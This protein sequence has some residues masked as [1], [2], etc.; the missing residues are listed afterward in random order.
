MSEY[1]RPELLSDRHDLSGFDC[2]SDVLNEWLRRFAGQAMR[3]DMGRVFVVTPKGSNNVVAFYGLTVGAI[4]QE[5]ATDAL[6]RRVGNYPIPVVLLTRLGVDEGHA[7]Q[8]LG[9]GLMRDAFLRTID[10]STQVGIRAFHVHA[11]DDQALKFYLA[12]A[13]FEP[14]P[15]SPLHLMIAMKDV[16]AALGA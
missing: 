5:D 1:I 10:A 4:E 6:R 9:R 8:G 3:N 14:S 13:E 11:K 15:T 2:G 16:V 12:L 7:G